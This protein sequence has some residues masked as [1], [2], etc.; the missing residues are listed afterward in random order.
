M[1]V[2]IESLYIMAAEKVTISMQQQDKHRTYKIGNYRIST[3]INCVSTGGKCFPKECL[4]SFIRV[5]TCDIYF[6]NRASR[7]VLFFERFKCF[8]SSVPLQ[9]T[10]S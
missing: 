2:Q 3:N 5:G 8:I 1:A 10:I 4:Q 9:S 7:L 6:F